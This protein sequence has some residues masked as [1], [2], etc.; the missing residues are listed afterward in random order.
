M[1]RKHIDGLPALYLDC[2]TDID[3]ERDTDAQSAFAR[4]IRD[5]SD[6]VR[7]LREA[8][9]AD[10]SCMIWLSKDCNQPRGI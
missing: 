7:A 4:Q 9:C 2:D 8:R 1:L 6:H 5:F 3:L 10:G